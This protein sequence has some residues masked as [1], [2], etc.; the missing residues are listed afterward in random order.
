MRALGDTLI[1]TPPLI[2]TPEGIDDAVDRFTRALDLGL[3]L[4]TTKGIALDKAA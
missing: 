2:I 3:D 1:M 4:L